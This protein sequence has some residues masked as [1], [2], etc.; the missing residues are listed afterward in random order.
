MISVPLARSFRVVPG[1]TLVLSL[2]AGPPPAEATVLDF[3]T[4]A[5][6]LHAA[7]VPVVPGGDPVLTITAVTLLNETDDALV[8]GTASQ[9]FWGTLGDLNDSQCSMPNPACEGLGVT[10]D[11]MGMNPGIEACDIDAMGMGNVDEALRF[12][13]AGNSILASSVKLSLVGLNTGEMSNNDVINL[14]LEFTPNE[15]PSDK[16]VAPITFTA[17]SN[18]FI[19]DFATL[20]DGSIFLNT[21]TFGSFAIRAATTQGQFGVSALEYSTVGATA[22]PEPASLFLLGTGLVGLGRIA[23][24]R[25][26]GQKR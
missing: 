23:S 5:D 21:S 14:Y 4:G 17:T 16:I 25:S 13:W 7:L 18:P 24:R 19:L 12:S 26:R 22:V 8:S 6:T 10:N 11:S 20:V 2:V 15:S 1:L 9:V 3:T